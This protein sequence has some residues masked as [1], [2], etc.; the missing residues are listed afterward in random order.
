VTSEGHVAED[1]LFDGQF[2]CSECWARWLQQPF[3]HQFTVADDNTVGARALMGAQVVVTDEH[4]TRHGCRA[5]VLDPYAQPGRVRVQVLQGSLEDQGETPISS[6]RNVHHRHLRPLTWNAKSA[7]RV[8]ATCAKHTSVLAAPRHAKDATAL[9]RM[10]AAELQLW[11]GSTRSHDVNSVQ[12]LY[13]CDLG[14]GLGDEAAWFAEELGAV[15]TMVDVWEAAGEAIPW[16]KNGRLEVACPLDLLSLCDLIDTELRGWRGHFHAVW[17][18]ASLA[19]LTRP[20]LSQLL[21]AL[22]FSMH[23]QGMLGMVMPADRDACAATWV[24]DNDLEY[25]EAEVLQQELSASGWEVRHCATVQEC[26]KS[27]KWLHVLATSL[28]QEPRE[29]PLLDTILNCHS[30]WTNRPGRSSHGGSFDHSSQ[31]DRFLR[32]NG[33]QMLDLPFEADIKDRAGWVGQLLHD[34]FGLTRWQSLGEGDREVYAF[35]AN[36][37]SGG[38]QPHEVYVIADSSEIES[39]EGKPMLYHYNVFWHA[40]QALCEL[41]DTLWCHLKKQL[42]EGSILVAFTAFYYRTCWK[43]GEVSFPAI[44]RDF[45]HVVG[46]LTHAAMVLGRHCTLLESISHESLAGLLGIRERGPHAQ[47]PQA[48]CAITR[49]AA[50]DA[51]NFQLPRAQL[52]IPWRNPHGEMNGA[53]P[54][55]AADAHM[56]TTKPPYAGLGSSGRGLWVQPPHASIPYPWTGKELRQLIAQRRSYVDF[57]DGEPL[58]SDALFVILRS[59]LPGSAPL[60]AFRCARILVPLILVF[61]HRVEGLLPGLYAFVRDMS[62]LQWLQRCVHHGPCLYQWKRVEEAPKDLALYLLDHADVRDCADACTL[63]QGKL[64][65]GA[66]V[67]MMLG[68]YVP[69]LRDHG[70]W[71]YR[72]LLWEAGAIGQA[73][74]ISAEGVGANGTGHG[75]YFGSTANEFLGVDAVELQDLY[76]FVIGTGR[77]DVRNKLPAY[78]HLGFYRG[79]PDRDAVQTTFSYAVGGGENFDGAA[80]RVCG[81]S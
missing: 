61:V 26:D 2:F 30:K 25:Y 55:L 7:P 81:R 15:V 36:P 33:T 28:A 21:Q 73:L 52:P 78:D 48:I 34:A 5:V 40:L 65:K 17:A 22:H 72:R 14:S 10:L 38:L 31:P 29:G 75:A 42:P 20:E 37:S 63:G 53:I 43:Y 79:L 64:Q 59:I 35:R 27:G 18:N 23:P 80:L 46:C 69:A 3:H 50:I 1:K 11:R 57:E 9:Q 47:Q 51:W 44:Q 19:H 76:H 8:V 24:T 32:F 12:P 6:S 54:Q 45:G 71:L 13:I 39:V 49:G 70:P 67:F 77:V 62:Q 60:A 66:V 16:V 4:T 74:Y 68:E 41:P 56:A 58:S